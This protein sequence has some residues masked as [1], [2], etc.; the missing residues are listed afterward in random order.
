[1]NKEEA[2]K[3]IEDNAAT[4]NES[5]LDFIHERWTFNEVAFWKYYNSIKLLAFELRNEESLSRDLTYKIIK[6]NQY[7]LLLIG[8]HF[9]KNDL[10]EIKN[11]PDN[12]TQFSER[13]R[14]AIDAFLTGSPI[15]DET[16]ELLDN[17]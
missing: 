8:C 14:I 9:D 17:D 1:M 5:F 7:Y 6:S 3:I 2:K 16:E 13:L 15:N 4:E 10:F 11:L 12:Y